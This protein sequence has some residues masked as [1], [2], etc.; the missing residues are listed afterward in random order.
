MRSFLKVFV[1]AVVLVALVLPVTV[2][3]KD[4]EFYASTKGVDG[5]NGSAT[6][7]R[8]VENED[9]LKD[10]C[11]VFGATLASDKVIAILYWYKEDEG[12]YYKYRLNKAGDFIPAGSGS[13]E[14]PGFG[15]PLSPP[16][17]VG[18]LSVLG[19][20]LLCTAW[21]IRRR[22]LTKTQPT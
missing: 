22:T 8:L 18:G 9:D 2:Y 19:V 10:A 15:V 1:L 13:G 20:L 4:P 11:K 17:I 3:A 7:P 12:K 6:Q 14:P 21:L 16:L 5:G